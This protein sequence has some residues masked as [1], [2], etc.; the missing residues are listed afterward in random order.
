MVLQ[1][2]NQKVLVVAVLGPKQ[3][4]QPWTR[5]ASGAQLDQAIGSEISALLREGRLGE[6]STRFRLWA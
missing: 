4:S 2:K 6:A 5:E 3:R 1:A